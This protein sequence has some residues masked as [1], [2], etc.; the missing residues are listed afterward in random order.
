MKCAGCSAAVDGINVLCRA[1]W[2]LLSSNQRRLISLLPPG[3]RAPELIKLVRQV[4]ATEEVE[5]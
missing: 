2:L 5:G 1:C 4:K 3:D